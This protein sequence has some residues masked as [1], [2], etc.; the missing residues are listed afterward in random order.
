MESCC[1]FA[2]YPSRSLCGCHDDDDEGE[3]EKRVR[4]EEVIQGD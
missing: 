4:K 2:W 1:C 3:E